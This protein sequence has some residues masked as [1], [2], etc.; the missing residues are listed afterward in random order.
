[1]RFILP[2]VAT[3]IVVSAAPA[4][5]TPSQLVESPTTEVAPNPARQSVLHPAQASGVEVGW[6][7]IPSIDVDEVIRSG[8]SLD[9]IDRGVAHWVGTAGAGEPGN[10]VLAGHRT[11]HTRPFWALDALDSG[12]LIYLADGDGFDV[13]YRVV[14]SFVVEPNA[15]WITYESGAPTLTMFAC[16]PKGSA[17]YRLVVKAEMVARRHIA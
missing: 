9:V 2:L 3:F 13:I 10:V 6:I 16:H 5:A 12:D 4:V 7:R 17:R 15:M 11:T 14:D 1:M 8:I